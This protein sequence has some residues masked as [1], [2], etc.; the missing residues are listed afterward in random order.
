MFCQQ[1]CPYLRGL[2]TSKDTAHY[3]PNSSPGVDAF[4]STDTFCSLPP[5]EVV[6]DV[7][8]AYF[9]WC[10]NQPYSYFHEETFRQKLARGVLPRCLVFAVLASGARYSKHEH[11][12]ESS[13]EATKSYAREAWMIVLTNHMPSDNPPELFVAQ[14]LNILAI[15]D[16]T[17]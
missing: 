10:H 4:R 7:V 9:H 5:N 8:G 11:F 6:Q 16:F 14:T 1:S 3:N 17:G 12:G 13:H 2:R 15:I